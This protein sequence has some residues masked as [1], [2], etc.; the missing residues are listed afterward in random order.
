MKRSLDIRDIQA[1]NDLQTDLSRFA[2]ETQDGLRVTQTEIARTQDWLRERVAHWQREVERAKRQVM[3]AKANLARCQSAV[4]RDRQGNYRRPDCSREHLA[5]EQA[6][7]LLRTCQEKLKTVNAWHTRVEQVIAEYQREAQRL[8]DLATGQTERARSKLGQLATRYRAVES[9]ASSIR[10]SST[11][12]PSPR[13]PISVDA[14]VSTASSGITWAEQQ[15][16]LRRVERGE[17][18]NL[19]E[20]ENLAAPASDLR[21]E[22][23]QLEDR[24]WIEELLTSERFREA[25]R[26]LWTAQTPE[27]TW[28]S[29]LQSLLGV[30]GGTAK[31]LLF[32]KNLE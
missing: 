22:T 30:V 27:A 11:A 29:I 9:A 7:T 4:H 15:A 21:A 25:T 2:D 8:R 24:A 31:L 28:G 10:T 19:T 6:G 1:L 18:I 20:L 5:F 12:A 13:S 14:P 32:W 23:I 26:G 17:S 3:Q 16:I